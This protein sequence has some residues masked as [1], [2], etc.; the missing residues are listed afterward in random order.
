MV[1]GAVDAVSDFIDSIIEEIKH[2][3]EV[4]KN[5]FTKNL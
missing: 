4:I 1:L 3:S 5:I 2:C